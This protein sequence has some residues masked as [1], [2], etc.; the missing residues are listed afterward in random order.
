[1]E[2]LQIQ[3]LE[4]NEAR[5]QVK[6][7]HKLAVSDKVIDKRDTSRAGKLLEKI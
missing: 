5:E 3:K 2:S 1:M 4:T 6:I 7:S